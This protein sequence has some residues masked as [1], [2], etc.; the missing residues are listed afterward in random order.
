M[1]D[2]ARA[3]P[4]NF[5]LRSLP[6]A[7]RK[8]V[9]PKLEHVELEHGKVLYSPDQTISHVYFV[10]A[11]MV[12]VI[13]YTEEGQSSEV[14][15]V[16]S[17]GMVGVEVILG[18][19]RAANELM[20]QHPD[21]GWRM[22]TADIREEFARG[23]AMHDL[24]LDFLRKLLFQISQTALCN[25]LHTAEQR[26]SRWLLM[27]HDRSASDRLP[28]TQEFLSVMLGVTR[29][30]VSIIAGELQKSGLIK[31]SRGMITILDRK[32]LEGHTCT[33]YN[34]IQR[35]YSDNPVDIHKL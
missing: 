20:V 35:G 26:L 10:G 7:D 33:C 24:L 30:S 25:R 27:C 5:I 17:E 3:T 11:A 4:D 12:S 22:T 19:D 13:A 18:A 32:G 23:G 31:Y 9:L 6:D 8:R 15:V 2:E 1:N 16:G 21:G 29:T 34:I 14:A 28:L